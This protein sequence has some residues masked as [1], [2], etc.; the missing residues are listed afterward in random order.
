M[1]H[2]L[3]FTAS[4]LAGFILLLFMGSQV[5]GQGVY[6]SLQGG[7]A[8]GY[9]GEEYREGAARQITALDSITTVEGL[10]GTNGQ[11]VQAGLALGYF[12]GEHAG[13]ELKVQSVFGAWRVVDQIDNRIQD[14]FEEL[15]ARSWQLRLQPAL[16]LRTRSE[17]NYLYVRSA[18]NIAIAGNTRESY[19]LS[20]PGGFISQA[21]SVEDISY[22]ISLGFSGALGLNFELSEKIDLLV[23]LE[24]H[25][26]RARPGSGSFTRLIVN[27]QDQL[28]GATPFDSQRNYV[29]EINQDSN[30]LAN[31]N[32]DL[33]APEDVLSKPSNFSSIGAN[34][35]IRFNF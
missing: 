31:P 8:L 30:T 1:F 3:K 33:N 19:M 18:I 23:E 12:F 34:V 7:Y 16:V 35:G 29:D 13:I 25:T 24:G 20:F 17:G 9:P 28:D 10:Y 21:E 5:R 14:F 27:G 15:Q 6:L 4:F 11:G 2:K 32:L 26:L 22:R